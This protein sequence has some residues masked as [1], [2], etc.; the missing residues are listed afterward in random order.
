MAEQSNNFFRLRIGEKQPEIGAISLEPVDLRLELG[1][2]LLENAD[3]GLEFFVFKG[4]IVEFKGELLDFEGEFR[5]LQGEF[6]DFT[7]QNGGFWLKTTDLVPKLAQMLKS[8]CQD[9]ISN[10]TAL[11][12]RGGN[13]HFNTSPCGKT[14]SRG[15]NTSGLS[16]LI[17][18][19]G[20]SGEI[21]HTRPPV[22]SRPFTANVASVA[23][24]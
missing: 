23:P 4:E 14:R 8:S 12:E 21:S 20:F 24:E 6:C 2:M 13:R 10:S 7:P 5:D 11:T 9:L 3:F 19:R 16:G 1:K 22:T 17:S 18:W 15:A